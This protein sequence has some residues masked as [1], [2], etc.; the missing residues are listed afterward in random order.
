MS[1]ISPSGEGRSRAV[2]E[3]DIGPHS[4]TPSRRSGRPANASRLLGAGD[5]GWLVIAGCDRDDERKGRRDYLRGS[6]VRA[7][8]TR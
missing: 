8:T 5:M 6:F 3:G 4:P 2:R 7:R 1:D